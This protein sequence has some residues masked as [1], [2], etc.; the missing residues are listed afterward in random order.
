[1]TM[2]RTAALTWLCLSGTASADTLVHNVNGYTWS[3]GEIVGFA[4]LLIDDAGRVVATGETGTFDGVD[5]ERVDG[6][7]ATMLPGLIDAHAHPLALG[8]LRRQVDLSGAHSL[9]NALERVQDYHR[10]QPDAVWILGRGW[11]QELWPER[12]FPNAAA[13]DEIVAERPRQRGRARPPR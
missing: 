7:G 6:A 2:S 5:T 4:E 10:T 12:A 11:N 1:M 3:E 9:E 13:L 8:R